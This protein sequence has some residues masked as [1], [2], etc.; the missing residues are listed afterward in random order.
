MIRAQ[1]A[2]LLGTP[3]AKGWAAILCVVAA[4]AVPT[5]IRAAVNGAVTGCEFTPYLPFVLVSAIML[6]WWQA[7]FVAVASVCI[8]GGLF[9]GSLLNPVACFIPAAG[10]F[11]ASSAAMIGATVL[12][13]RLV[14]SFLNHDL[15]EAKGGA[16]FSVENGEV[17]VS[18]YGQGSPLRL[19]TQAKVS[20]MMRDYLA[21]EKI[22]KRLTRES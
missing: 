14:A 10:M 6:R 16:V 12:G 2:R 19:G 22:A 8:M 21:Q 4:V 15:D 11:I 18:W 17:W 5:V 20:E 7:A 13:R 9:Q 1:A 3:V